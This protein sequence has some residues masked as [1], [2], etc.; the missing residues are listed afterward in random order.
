MSEWEKLLAQKA[1]NLFGLDDWAG[2]F[3]PCCLLK[4]GSQLQHNDMDMTI[5]AKDYAYVIMFLLC[6]L[7]CVV[8]TGYIKHK[9]FVK[10]LHV[11]FANSKLILTLQDLV[12]VQGPWLLQNILRS[13]SCVEFKRTGKVL[14]NISWNYM[15]CFISLF[16]TTHYYNQGLSVVSTQGK[17]VSSN[18][19][20]KTS[21][22]D[23]K[24]ISP[25]MVHR[26]VWRKQRK[27]PSPHPL[28]FPLSSL[29]CSPCLQMKQME[30]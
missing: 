22:T 18:A 1:G 16:Y 3:K 26:A 5:K 23:I 2:F 28:L 9:P 8:H 11:C 27:N 6:C 10:H 21:V 14:N 4:P 17:W 13:H 30:L 12:T 24:P 7:S 15:Y 25:M 19:Q 29:C 20:N